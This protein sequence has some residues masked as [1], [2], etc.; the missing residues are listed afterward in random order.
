VTTGILVL[1]SP[2]S[3]LPS[4]EIFR[5]LFVLEF[6]AA[7]TVRMTMMMMV[8]QVDPDLGHEKRRRSAS[9]IPVLKW[10][11]QRRNTKN[12]AIQSLNF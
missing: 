4:T 8:L 1:P 10:K 11:M 12:E 5:E 6:N 2:F 9:R 3:G 7:E